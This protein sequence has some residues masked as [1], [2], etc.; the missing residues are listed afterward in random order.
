[1][2]LL[3]EWPL[4]TGDTRGTAL[5]VMSEDTEAQVRQAEW[6]DIGRR[7][8]TI[9]K[10]ERLALHP[11][12]SNPIRAEMQAYQERRE[13]KN[14]AKE[15]ARLGVA[16]DEAWAEYADRER[17]AKLARAIRKLRVRK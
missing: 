9:P 10:E 1:M 16:E 8:A 11:S 17:Q 12:I 15:S 3:S 14:K 4:L 7:W 13:R 6:A 5:R 2:A